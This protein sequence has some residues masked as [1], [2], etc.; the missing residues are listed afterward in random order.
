MKKLVNGKVVNINNIELFELAAEGIALQNTAVS[1]TSDGIEADINTPTLHKYIKQYNIFFKSMPYP[2]YAVENDIK[3]ATLGNFIKALAK[4]KIIMWVNSGLHIKLDIS[5]GMTLKIVNNTWSI[6][7]VKEQYNDNTSL[8]LFKNK[9][10]YNEYSWLLKKVINKETTAN[11]YKE[12]MPEFVAACNNQPMMLKWELENMLTFSAIPNRIELK[13]NKI[14]NIQKDEEYSLDIFCN[15]SV[16]TNEKMQSWSIGDK[17]DSNGSIFKQLKTYDFDTYLK[18][19]TDDVSKPSKLEKTNIPGLQTLFMQLCAIKNAKCIDGFSEFYGVISD[20]NL[21]FTI[22][23]R[24]F[25]AKSTR[26]VEAKDIAHGIDLYT[27]E[28]GKIYFIKSKK[29]TE[30]ISKDT[31]YSYN[32]SDGSVRLC[33]IIFS[34]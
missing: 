28:N 11:F 19:L 31:M 27:V 18:K 15:G 22:D 3:Y 21:I 13:Q 24:L 7:Y 30:Q 17:I 5:S 9:V 26:A 23:K 12:F 1:T 20:A 8:E 4:E 6:T 29:V 32:I 16:Q 33:K 25:V 14:V 10:G 2:L 34:Y